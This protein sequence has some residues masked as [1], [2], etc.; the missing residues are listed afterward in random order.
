MLLTQR[1]SKEL[2]QRISAAYL[3]RC[4][5]TK[6]VNRNHALRQSLQPILEAPHLALQLCALLQDVDDEYMVIL[7]RV[8]EV[9]C[10]IA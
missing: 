3:E 2:L 6:L 10:A 4:N 8:A 9:Q 1:T 7:C 5:F